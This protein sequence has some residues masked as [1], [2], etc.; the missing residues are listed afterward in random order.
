MIKNEIERTV[1]NAV[2]KLEKD[3]KA[4]MLDKL[5]TTS[6][7]AGPS[8]ADHEGQEDSHEEFYIDHP[9]VMKRFPVFRA[10]SLTTD[11]EQDPNAH[12]RK[13]SNFSHQIQLRE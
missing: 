1:S 4:Y 7:N 2:K 9:S 11:A 10:E 3:I 13:A 5:A 8:D 6:A 12:P